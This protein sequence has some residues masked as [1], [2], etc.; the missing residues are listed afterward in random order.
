MRKLNNII[1]EFESEDEFKDFKNYY[2]NNIDFDKIEDY[3]STYTYAGSTELEIKNNQI[4]IGLGLYMKEK[5]IDYKKLID[6]I[7]DKKGE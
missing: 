3:G 7:K 4:E 1:I 2:M 5:Y 6:N